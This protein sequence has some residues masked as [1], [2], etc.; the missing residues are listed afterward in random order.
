MRGVDSGIALLTDV[1][2]LRNPGLREGVQMNIQRRLKLL[3][4][5][6]ISEPIVLQMPDGRTETLRG[7]RYYTLDLFKR[8]ISG[9]RTPEMELIAQCTS[10]IEP[11]GG[12]MIELVQAILN[13]P[14]EDSLDP[15]T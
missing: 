9:D 8:A 3:E 5:R 1:V 2:K 15:T 6:L 10:S 7:P 14:K 12:R 4:K 11:G 13:G